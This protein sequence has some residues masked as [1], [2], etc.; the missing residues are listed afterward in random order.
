MNATA[1]ALTSNAAA[2][3][4][5]HQQENANVADVETMAT[6]VITST[7]ATSTAQAQSFI[8]FSQ[9]STPPLTY[10]I[11]PVNSTA[12]IDDQLVNSTLTGTADDF[13]EFSTNIEKQDVLSTSGNSIIDAEVQMQD[14][15]KQTVSLRADAEVFSLNRSTA[16]DTSV[17]YAKSYITSVQQQ[18]QQQDTSANNS[19]V[20]KVRVKFCNL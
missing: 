7:M 1:A 8:N 20:C 14:A 11:D 4:A 2:Q 19:N 3:A 15:M 18:Q 16:S 9:I 5:Q 13:I 6:N 10:E 12:Q 17:N